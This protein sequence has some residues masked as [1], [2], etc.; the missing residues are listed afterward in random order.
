MSNYNIER[1]LEKMNQQMK[2]Q[3]ISP[4]E[5]F[6]CLALACAVEYLGE[7]SGTPEDVLKV[8]EQFY[9]WLKECP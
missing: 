9:E 4:A 3:W 1:Q 5:R 6:R 8:A 2:S 7:A